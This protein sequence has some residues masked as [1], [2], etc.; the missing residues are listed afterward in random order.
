MALNEGVATANYIFGVKEGIKLEG[1]KTEKV[2]MEGEDGIMIEGLGAS[3]SDHRLVPTAV[4]AQ[5]PLS[6]VSYVIH[7]PFL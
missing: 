7:F 1:R 3:V 2:H 5:P 4:F 6:A